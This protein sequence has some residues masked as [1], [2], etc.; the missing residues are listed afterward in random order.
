[1]LYRPHFCVDSTT[2][3]FGGAGDL[4]L[5]WNRQPI[6][7]SEVDEVLQYFRG[8]DFDGVDESRL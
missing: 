2:A 1:M 5:Y 3:E 4:R 7:F 8:A 6:N